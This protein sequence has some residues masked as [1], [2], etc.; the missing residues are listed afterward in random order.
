VAASS[1]SL[2]LLLV[3]T[4]P[5]QSTKERGK[6][7]AHA[8]YFLFLMFSPCI[9]YCSTLAASTLIKLFLK[10]LKFYQKIQ[11]NKKL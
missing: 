1:S 11:W 8:I 2:L 7:K 10:Q 3:N 5:N 4:K 6:K 9:M